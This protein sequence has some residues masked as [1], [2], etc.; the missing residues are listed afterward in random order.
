MVEVLGLG[1]EFPDDGAIPT[2]SEN[3]A[4][5]APIVEWLRRPAYGVSG[6]AVVVTDAMQSFIMCAG[7]VVTIAAITWC[8]GCA[9][10]LGPP[11]TGIMPTAGSPTTA[12]AATT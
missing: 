11:R 9:G 8:G 5:R 2:G 7:A 3:Y 4:L 12:A 10:Y 1:A 6:D